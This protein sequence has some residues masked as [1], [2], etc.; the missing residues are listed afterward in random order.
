MGETRKRVRRVTCTRGVTGWSRIRSTTWAGTSSRPA[1]RS[2]YERGAGRLDVPA[3]VV[4]RIRDQPVTPRV[5][6]TRRT[7]F[8]VSPI[9]RLDRGPLHS[10]EDAG[11][12]VGLQPAYQADQIGAAAHPSDAPSSHVV[13]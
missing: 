11:I 3:Q 4:E 13:G 7:R 10:L 9:Q 2:M 1:P 8:L 5:H 6:V 12:D